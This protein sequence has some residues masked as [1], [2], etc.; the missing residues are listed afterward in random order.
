M[1]GMKL[2]VF[3]A[4]NN[5]DEEFSA[6]DASSDLLTSSGPIVAFHGL[7]ENTTVTCIARIG[8]YKLFDNPQPTSKYT[9]SVEPI[10]R[11][12]HLGIKNS[13]ELLY[14]AV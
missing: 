13:A 12:T 14:V 11:Y 6:A 8:G 1:K 9:F 2:I 4:S 5:T 3:R 7:M 10:I